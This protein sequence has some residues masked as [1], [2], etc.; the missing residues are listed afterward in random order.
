MD[1]LQKIILKYEE[2][3]IIWKKQREILFNEKNFDQESILHSKSILLWSV[4]KD[5][6]KLQ[7]KT[8]K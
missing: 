6:K 2:Q 8:T 7:Q 5:L 1:E 3:I 4:I